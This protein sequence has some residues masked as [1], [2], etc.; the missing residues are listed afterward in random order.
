VRR[1]LGLGLLVLVLVVFLILFADR[2][3]RVLGRVFAAAQAPAS[4]PA[5]SQPSLEE[6]REARRRLLPTLF[7]GSLVGVVDRVDFGEETQK[8]RRLLEILWAYPPG[9]VTRRATGELDYETSLRDPDLVRGEF[10][11]VR[12]LV[13]EIGATLLKAPIAGRTDVYR[14]FLTDT[15]GSRGLAFDLPD[16]PPQGLSLRR[17]VVDVEGI[18]YRVARYE[19]RRGAFREVPYLLARN[20]KVADRVR[21]GTGFPPLLPVVLALAVGTAVAIMLGSRRSRGRS[22]RRAGFREMF[23]RKL[24]GEGRPLRPDPPA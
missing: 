16:P 9:E 10:V 12:G 3:P 1:I 5:A 19:T 17:D 23:D 22:A 2:T 14:G 20:L 7:E 4:A 18:F 13:I 15:D 21:R 11:R 6:R 8:Y 24:R